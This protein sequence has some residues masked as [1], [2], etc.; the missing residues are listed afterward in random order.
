MY[1]TFIKVAQEEGEKG[2]EMVFTRAKL[3]EGV[4]AE[5]YLDAYN[6]IDCPDDDSFYLCPACGYIHKGG[7]FEKCPIC[8]T[9]R[10]SFKEF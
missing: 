9:P 1:P 4:H 2:A 3:A 8:F 5:L 6:N 7:D 10:A